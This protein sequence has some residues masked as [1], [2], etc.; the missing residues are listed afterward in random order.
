MAEI[1]ENGH[2]YKLRQVTNAIKVIGDWTFGNHTN[3]LAMVACQD[4]ANR[5]LAISGTDVDVPIDPTDWEEIT[6]EEFNSL[7]EI[8]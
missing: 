7:K 2:Y 8:L 4:E 3:R 5:P 1:F 6:Q